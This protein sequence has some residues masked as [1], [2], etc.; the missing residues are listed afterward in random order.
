MEKDI[1]A[2][3]NEHIARYSLKDLSGGQVFDTEQQNRD[4]KTIFDSMEIGSD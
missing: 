1:E 3:K 4:A 2:F